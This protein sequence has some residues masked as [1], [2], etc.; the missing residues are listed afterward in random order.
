MERPAV[1]SA[2]TGSSYHKWNASPPAITAFRREIR[3]LVESTGDEVRELHFSDGTHT[4]ERGANRGTHNSG[5]GNRSIDD[6]PLAKF[7]QHSGS[8]FECASVDAYILAEDEYTLVLLH[9]FPNALANR[10]DVSSEAHFF[11]GSALSRLHSL[12]SCLLFEINVF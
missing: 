3:D 5:L 9:F 7:F 8:N 4:H 6:P 2:A 1:N 11:N 12:R 10:F